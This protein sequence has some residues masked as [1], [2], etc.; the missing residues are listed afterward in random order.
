MSYY[1]FLNALLILLSGLLTFAG[2]SFCRLWQ[3]CE[4]EAAFVPPWLLE[5][6]AVRIKVL[7]EF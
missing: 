6:H 1:T 7:F 2:W 5:H 4:G 3:H